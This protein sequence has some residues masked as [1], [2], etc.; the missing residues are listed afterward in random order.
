VKRN[1]A[2]WLIITLV[3]VKLGTV[4]LDELLNCT[5]RSVDLDCREPSVSLKSSC[6]RRL[7]TIP[8][9]SRMDF[10]TETLS[11][12]LVTSILKSATRDSHDTVAYMCCHG[13]AVNKPLLKHMGGSHMLCQVELRSS[14]LLYNR[15]WVSHYVLVSST[16]VGLVARYYFLSECCCLKAAVLFL[17]GAFSDERT[18]LQFSV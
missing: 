18:G 8:L 11:T 16:L 14:K 6:D 1:L 5:G 15:R 9:L 10:A 7:A 17:W 13:N 12:N 2:P 3:E 4:S